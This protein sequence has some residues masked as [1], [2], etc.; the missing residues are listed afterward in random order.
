MT[1]IPATTIMK[2]A[3]EVVIGLVLT[4]RPNVESGRGD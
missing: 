2:I 3:G 1:K 4:G